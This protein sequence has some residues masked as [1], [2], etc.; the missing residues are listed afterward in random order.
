[1]HHQKSYCKL[2]LVIEYP[3]PSQRL[4]WDYKKANL[5][6]IKQELYQVNWSTILSNKDLHQQVNILNKLILNVFTNYVCNKVVTIDGKDPPWM[7]HF[8]KSKTEWQNSIY[9][10]FQNSFK[11]LAEYNKW[12]QAITEVSDLIYEKKND[13]YNAL[14]KK[15]SDPTTSSKTY[16]FILKTFYNTKKVPIIHPTDFLKNANYFDKL[17]ASKSTPLIN[18]SLPTSLNFE[19]RS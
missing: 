13:Y 1:M 12:Q 19:K 2:N 11:N 4:V 17:F 10:T 16:W 7:A 5:N 9:K 6:P 15:L 14:A 3:P 8:K 18:S